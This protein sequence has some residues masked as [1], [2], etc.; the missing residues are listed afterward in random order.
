LSAI[1]ACKV[2]TIGLV[3]AQSFT[4]SSATVGSDIT[5]SPERISNG[6]ARYVDRAATAY[7]GATSMTLSV[8]PP[9]KDSRVTKV[10]H[11][12]HY[13]VLETNGDSSASGI[14]PAPTKAYELMYKAEWFLPERSTLAQRIVFLS[15]VTSTFLYSCRASD[16]TPED[17]TATPLTGAILN[18]EAVYGS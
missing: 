3:S 4:T 9:T 14:L 17:A 2:T 13:P 1:A 16:G 12:L 10:T 5:L 7:V 11:M 15:I 6:V 18:L 8:R